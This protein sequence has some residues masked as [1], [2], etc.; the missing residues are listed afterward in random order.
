MVDDVDFVTFQ[1]IVFDLGIKYNIKFMLQQET[2]FILT[3][4]QDNIIRPNNYSKGNKIIIENF[5]KFN[6]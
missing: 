2:D 5:E 6:I 4:C 3:C 1:E